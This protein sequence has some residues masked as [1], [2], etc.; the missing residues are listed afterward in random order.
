MSIPFFYEPVKLRKS[1]LVDGGLLLNFPI[2]ILDRPNGLKPRWPTF[3][4]KLPAKSELNTTINPVHSTRD[5]AKALL[6]TMQAAHD[7]MHFEEPSAVKRT[8]FVDSGVIH[9]TDF[10]ITK[11]QQNQLFN[12]GQLAATKFLQTWN[13][14][15]YCF[16]C[17]KRPLL[18]Q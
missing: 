2:S 15:A 14:D 5:L 17:R 8:M 4:I 18:S 3:G 10:N 9:P 12:A 1:L 13:F 16:E 7:R 6:V 11:S